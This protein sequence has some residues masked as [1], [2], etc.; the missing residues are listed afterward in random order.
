MNQ[1]NFNN[2][3]RININTNLNMNT[4]FE[5]KYD[6]EFI[7]LLNEI[8]I[9]IGNFNKCDILKIKSWVNILMLPFDSKEDKR[10]RNLYS[11]KLIN[12]MIN[13]RLEEPFIKFANNV[14]DLKLI[15]A[16]NVKA[17]L[18]KKF[19][20]EIDFEKI[21]NYGHQRQKKFLQT[22]PELAE[23]LKKSNINIVNSSNNNKNNYDKNSN[24]IDNIDNINDNNKMNKKSKSMNNIKIKKNDLFFN[25]G[26]NN[27]NNNISNYGVNRI[28]M[29]GYSNN[30]NNN[31]NSKFKSKKAVF[32]KPFDGFSSISK[33]QSRLAELS[34]NDL[35][36]II[37]DLQ[38]TINQK[39]DLI[40]Y[41]NGQLEQMKNILE[42]LKKN[43]HY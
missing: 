24:H 22:H 9:R 39:D 37:E 4:L 35:N 29:T 1:E 14:N 13:G 27:C 32:K 28:N 12:Q 10:N 8:S 6:N 41:Q 20:D 5:S 42:K 3:K 23:Q 25:F 43:I 16:I 11:I 21:E 19:F 33:R 15:S 34:V 18:S 7:G 38:I 31:S 30:S 36:K 26:S 2:N 40:S 17:E